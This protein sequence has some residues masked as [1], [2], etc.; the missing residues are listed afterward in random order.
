MVG[1]IGGKRL[2]FGVALA[3]EGVFFINAADGTEYEVSAIQKN[4]PSQLVFLV[5]TIPVGTQLQLEVRAY[6]GE[7]LRTGRLDDELTA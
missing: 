3:E 1:P 2:K 7:K 5:P 6:F 4:K